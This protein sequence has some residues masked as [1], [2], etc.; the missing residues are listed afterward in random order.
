MKPD[1]LI[2][3]HKMVLYNFDVIVEWIFQND[4]VHLTAVKFQVCGSHN[5]IRFM[6]ANVF[7]NIVND[8]EK[9]VLTSQ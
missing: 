5:L 7:K 9:E 2:H 6:S 3:L 8:I 4:T 1:K